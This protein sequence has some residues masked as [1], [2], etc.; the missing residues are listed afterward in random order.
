MFDLFCLWLQKY[1]SGSS[2]FCRNNIYQWLL[3]LWGWEEMW[4]VMWINAYYNYDIGGCELKSFLT[5]WSETLLAIS[6]WAASILLSISI[7]NFTKTHTK[8]SLGMCTG[9]SWMTLLYVKWEENSLSWWYH[10]CIYIRHTTNNVVIE[11]VNTV[12]LQHSVYHR[13]RLFMTVNY[14]EGICFALLTK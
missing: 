1:L 6:L 4:Y 10:V 14:R 5:L 12:S 3:Y 9:S 2:Y 13:N 7:A 8:S 11:C